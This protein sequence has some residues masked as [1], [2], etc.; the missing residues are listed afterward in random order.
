M[1]SEPLNLYSSLYRWAHRQSENFCTDALVFLINHLLKE[2]PSH[3]VRLIK[4]LCFKQEKAVDLDLK[5]LQVTTQR[6]EI[7]GTPDI[8]VQ[9]RTFL[10]LI[11]VKKGSDLHTGQL[12]Q[13]RLLLER[14]NHQHVRLVLLTVYEPTIESEQPDLHLYWSDVAGWIRANPPKQAASVFLFQQFEQFLRDQVMSFEQISWQ[15]T[16]GTKSFLTFSNMLDKAIKDA[17]IPQH[18]RVQSAWVQRGFFTEGQK[19]WVGIYLANPETLY[20]EFSSGI[21][22]PAKLAENPQFKE[23]NGKHALPLELNSESAHFFS[24]TAENQLTYLTEWLGN[25]YQAGM[26]CL[27]G[28]AERQQATKEIDETGSTQTAAETELPSNDLKNA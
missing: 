25:A 18:S 4:W 28:S 12:R 9:T 13:Y 26:R 27:K 20:F 16:E 22:D 10:C 1:S 5:T 11:E 7:E 14:S 3:G 19:F 15:F 23:V 2:E 24:R 8:R 17:K 6:R 21:P